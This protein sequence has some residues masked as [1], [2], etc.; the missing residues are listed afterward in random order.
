MVITVP[1]PRSAQIR[2][3]G[4]AVLRDVMNGHFHKVGFHLRGFWRALID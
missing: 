3:N 2:L 1:L 4:R